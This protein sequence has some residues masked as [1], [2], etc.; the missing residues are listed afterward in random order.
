MIY[1]PPRTPL[2]QSARARGLACTNGLSML[3]YQGVRSLE[4]WSESTVPVEAMFRGA[5]EGMNPC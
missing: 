2:L 3:I 5:R 4:I 1:N